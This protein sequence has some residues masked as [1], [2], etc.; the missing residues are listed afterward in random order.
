MTAT[1]PELIEAANTTLPKGWRLEAVELRKHK[2]RS[3]WRLTAYR[4][5]L[6]I[7]RWDVYR[8]GAALPAIM[9]RIGLA[10]DE[11]SSITVTADAGGWVK[12]IEETA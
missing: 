11:P 6:P 7:M 4:H 9:D 8:V 10:A 12:S 3:L 2:Y 1:V 5:G